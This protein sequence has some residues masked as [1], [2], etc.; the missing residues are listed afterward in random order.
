MKHAFILIAILLTYS[1]VSAK[2]Y[3]KAKIILLNG[4]IMEGLATFPEGPAPVPIRFKTDENS[5]VQSI[6]SDSI[7]TIVYLADNGNT[8]E[9]DRLT[10]YVNGPYEKPEKQW[11]H[12]VFRGVVTLY[13]YASVGNLQRYD[14]IQTSW[15]CVRQGEAIA[16]K[17][18][19]TDWKNRRNFFTNSATAYFKDDAELVKKIQNGEYTWKDV[20]KIVTEYNDWTKNKQKG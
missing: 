16:T 15:L 9:Y 18:T 6:N 7:K 10:G 8:T 20:D 5:R 2:K 12:V 11:L 1:S 3:S 14:D 19:S 17:M 13:T 4:T